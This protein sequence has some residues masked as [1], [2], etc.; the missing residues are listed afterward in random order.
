M[1]ITGAPIISAIL[2][3]TRL[4]LPARP[5][6][7]G[8]TKVPG[9]R[10]DVHV[11]YTEG[12]LPHV[13]ATSAPDLFFAQGYLTAADRLFQMDLFRRA[14]RGEMAEIVGGRQAP[15]RE[16]TALFRGWSMVDVDQFMRQLSLL[17]SAREAIDVLTPESRSLVQAYADGVNGWLKEG[18]RP[19]ECQL[20]GYRP[21]TW[22][23]IDCALVWKAMA[24][25]LSYG[26]RAGLVAEALRARFPNEPE[27]ARALVPNQR[28]VED[29]MLPVW[30]GAADLLRRVQA[31]AGPSNPT[32]GGLGGSNGW[33]IAPSRTKH[34]RAILC[35]D[36]HLPF[37]A[38]S[39]GYLVHLSG[40]GFDVAGWSI[41]GM[42]GV[43]MGHN[44]DV[45]WTLTS[46]CTLDAGWAMEQLSADGEQV[47]TATGFAPI[48][49]ESTDIVV[50][51]AKAAV[52]RVLRH[53]ANGPM[54]DS[55][56]AGDGPAGYALALR[57]TGHLATPDLATILD[58]DRARDFESFQQAGSKL[59]APQ[60]NA[61][62]ADVKGHIGWQFFGATPRF[63][64]VPP[65]GAV[66]GWSSQH[67]WEGIEH[68]ESLP[69]S[70]DP[71]DG[72][73]V[74]ANQ[75]LLAT[76]ARPQLGELFEPPYRSR[77]IR[78]RLQSDR[79]ATLQGASAV[80]LD[81]YSGFG[82]DLRDQFLKKL[83]ARLRSRQP[84]LQEEAEDVLNAASNWNGFATPESAGAAAAWSF[85]SALLRELFEKPLGESLFHAVFEQHN[86][87]LLPLL[88][89]LGHEGAP[90]L[91][92]EELDQ[93]CVR[94]LTFASQELVRQCGGGPSK[95]RLS[96][97][98][99]VSMRHPMSD[100]PILG[101][102]V[103][104]GPIPW[105]G[106]GSTVNCSAVTLDRSEHADIGPV[107]RHAVECG[108][109][110]NYR[111]IMATGQSG[112]PTSGRYRE[113]FARWR[114]GGFVTFPF[115]ADAIRKAEKSS[116]DLTPS[117]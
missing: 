116:A 98:R 42:P 5:P 91:S 24:F 82:V 73:V 83:E 90:F 58:L 9:L 106:D 63:K 16:L 22:T 79:S 38:P 112:D 92:M 89:I 6:V 88:K 57:W 7:R 53:S 101:S 41:P 103:T 30:P 45:A 113:L 52:R 115:S 102:I 18:Q 100:V 34:G 47:R 37:R 69:F 70:L 33:A 59:G 95:W 14:A 44:R 87:L 77:R 62:Y 68:F 96:A 17:P 104:I 29:V 67:E 85:V 84:P 110:D 64:A 81:L 28:A 40:G 114:A 107:F 46:G 49:T 75:R 74:S 12:G 99:S 27:K 3:R 72:L 109:W 105:A 11:A 10:S 55:K 117:H 1:A 2:D 36:P 111:V 43:V 48:E 50:R 4:L 76:D 35:G 97:L 94:A 21:R 86:L 26:W 66:P 31:T 39:A 65:M 19:L 93:A 71:P 32:G 8:L 54:F 20:L 56:L 80:Q 23:T 51:G 60:V 61:V 108:D 78:Q 25:Q 13:I 15:W